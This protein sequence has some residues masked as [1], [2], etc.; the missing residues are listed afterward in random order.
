VRAFCRYRSITSRGITIAICRSPS[1]SQLIGLAIGPA[2]EAVALVAAL[3]V[4]ALAVLGV[5]AAAG[6]AD[7]D[8]YA[9]CEP[10]QPLSHPPLEAAGWPCPL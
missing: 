4:F 8:L 3:A 2:A 7:A 5:L 6:C 10:N 9:G 1:S